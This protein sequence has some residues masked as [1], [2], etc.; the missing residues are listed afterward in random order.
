M[1][2]AGQA[3]VCTDVSFDAPS[4]CQDGLLYE[5]LAQAGEVC[6]HPRECAGDLRC[7]V[8]NNGD[9]YSTCQEL[10]SCAGS[11]CGEGQYCQAIGDTEECRP[12]KQLMQT[13]TASSECGLPGEGVCDFFATME[14]ETGRCASVS[15]ASG[16]EPAPPAGA[17]SP[18]E[19]SPQCAWPLLCS[20]GICQEVAPT[21]GAEGEACDPQLGKPELCTRGLVCGVSLSVDQEAMM[22]IVDGACRPASPA[23]GPCYLL[24]EC[25]PGHLCAGSNPQMLQPGQCVAAR[26]NGESCELDIEC[27]SGYCKALGAQG[28]CSSRSACV[29]P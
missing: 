19:V 14:P 7:Y 12:Y 29:L 22:L 27:D 16:P 28:Q 18:C 25:E 21:F 15:G 10:A 20:D 24:T 13:C 2:A 1:E 23:G 17:G 26:Q 6:L 8:E 9:C 5:G 4:E 3:S 11:T